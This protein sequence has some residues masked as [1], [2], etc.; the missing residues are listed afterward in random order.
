[1]NNIRFL[2]TYTLITALTIPLIILLYPHIHFLGGISFSVNE[3]ETVE[4][5]EEFLNDAGHPLDDYYHTIRIR[6]DRS[7]TMLAEN[8]WGFRKSNEA[9]RDSIPGYTRTFRWYVDPPNTIPAMLIPNQREQVAGNPHLHVDGNGRIT[10]FGYNIPDTLSYPSLNEDEARTLLETFIGQHTRFDPHRLDIESIERDEKQY[11]T[12][13]NFSFSGEDSFL[14][15]PVTIEVSVAGNTITRYRENYDLPEHLAREQTDLLM[16]L[17]L[18]IVYTLLVL[19]LLYF[20]ITRLRSGELGFQHAIPIGIIVFLCFGMQFWIT[21]ISDPEWLMLLGLVLNSVIVAMAVIIGWSTGESAGRQSWREKFIPFD[22]LLSG[23]GFHSMIGKAIIRGVAFGLLIFMFHSGLVTVINEITNL[24]INFPPELVNYLSSHIASFHLFTQSIT[25]SFLFSAIFIISFSSIIRQ[26]TPS[27]LLTI[28]LPA[29]LIAMAHSAMVQP[30]TGGFIILFLYGVAVTWIFYRFD[31]LTLLIAIIVSEMFEWGTVMFFA[32]DTF[33]LQQG[34]IW[35][36]GLACV[37]VVGVVSIYTKDREFKEQQITPSFQRFISERERLQREFEIAHEVQMGFLPPTTPVIEGLDIAARCIPAKEIGGDYYD[38]IEAGDHATAIVIGDVSG[39]GTKAAFYMTLAKGLIYANAERHTYQCCHILD[40]VNR[41]FYRNVD[42]SAFISMIYSV[43]NASSGELSLARAGHN[44]IIYYN[45]TT[46][47]ADFIRPQ[48]IAIGLHGG[49][50]FSD[51]INDV[52]LPL[53][54]NDII[55]FYTD[56]ITEA[57]NR[58]NEEFGN[59]RLFD[60]IKQYHT[61]D[62]QSILDN[63]FSEVL[64]FTKRVEQSDDMT[65]V[66]IKKK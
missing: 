16:Q 33:L 25:T 24:R 55:I 1:M 4:F 37:W 59:N 32:G 49:N 5:V 14:Q 30:I 60:T 28:G 11:R 12:D 31:V 35:T 34:F 20:A 51:T 43:Y 3:D 7:V 63:I 17:Q 40:N 8:R 50:V 26:R 48:G 27:L 23:H 21:N 38:F 9:F 64:K 61:E 65:M 57:M 10:Y 62:A 2:V 19:I 39:K 36:A 53:N 13:W 54:S 15:E 44:P 41:H 45:S 52:T 18:M 66:V 6:R 47:K 42:R 56:G 46:G 22:L 29:V 58:N